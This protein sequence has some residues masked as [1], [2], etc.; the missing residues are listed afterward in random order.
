MNENDKVTVVMTVKDVDAQFETIKSSDGV[1]VSYNHFSSREMAGT[2]ASVGDDVVQTLGKGDKIRVTGRIDFIGTWQV[3][4]E[5]VTS[6][7][8]IQ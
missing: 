7:E 1:E 2:Y 8:V 6:I 4:L 5:D 3:T